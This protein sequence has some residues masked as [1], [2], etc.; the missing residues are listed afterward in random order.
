M[1]PPAR[2]VVSGK[3]P[4]SYPPS[5]GARSNESFRLWCTSIEWWL[6]GE[7]NQLP[8]EVIG[9]RIMRQLEGDARLIC[10]K[11]KPEAVAT[12]GGKELILSTLAASPIIAEHEDDRSNK[13]QE[14]F[15]KLKRAS[16][17]SIDSFLS[18]VDISFSLLQEQDEAF[19]ISDRFMYAMVFEGC[20]LTQQDKMYVESNMQGDKSTAN[21]RR[22][23]RRLRNYLRGEVPIGK[24]TRDP[25]ADAVIRPHAGGRDQAAAPPWRSKG[26]GKG[27]PA[28]HVEEE[29][30]AVE[31]EAPQED[32]DEE[33]D[34][35][36]QLPSEFSEVEHEV[37]ATYQ[38]AKQKVNAVKQLRSYYKEKDHKGSK[39]KADGLRESPEERSARLKTLMADSTCRVCG[40]TGHWKNECPTRRSGGAA[41]SGSTPHTARAVGISASS[42]RGHWDLDRLEGLLD[43]RPRRGYKGNGEGAVLLKFWHVA[44]GGLNSVRTSCTLCSS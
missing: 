15:M 7:G 1:G 6:L 13:A 10:R 3:L 36:S 40:K 20:M 43:A 35:Q 23:L 12:T 42:S 44:C 22:T 11:L 16:N 17:E 37:H 29:P 4:N 9:P 21:L 31:Q 25:L 38:K 28:L 34:S 32:W 18:R 33:Y 2:K 14:Q 19:T 5:F 26:A 24:D 39:R 27:H 8:A 30:R 41:G